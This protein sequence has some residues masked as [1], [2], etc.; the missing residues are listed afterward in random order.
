MF[1][2]LTNNEHDNQTTYQNVGLIQNPQLGPN[3]ELLQF[4]TLNENHLGRYF[5]FIIFLIFSFSGK[6][7]SQALLAFLSIPPYALI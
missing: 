5:T 4:T 2:E 3:V 6:D 1:Q 7:Y